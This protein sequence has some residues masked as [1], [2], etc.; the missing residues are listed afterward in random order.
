M[1]TIMRSFILPALLI[2]ASCEPKPLDIDVK[3][4]PAAP[5]VSS[6]MT[7]DHS[8]VIAATYSFNS[9]IG[10]DDTLLDD[11]K[12]PE[13]LMIKDAVVTLAKDGGSADTLVPVSEG[14]FRNN[15]STP[16]NGASY[17]LNIYDRQSK[18]LATARSTYFRQPNVLKLEP[19]KII[20]QGDTA[21]RLHIKL[22]DV[23]PG[24]YYMVSYSTRG[25]RG[26]NPGNQGFFSSLAAYNP[27]QL[28]LLG[29]GEI[30][31]DG[32]DQTVTIAAKANDT[33]LVHCCRIDKAYYNYLNTYKKAGSFINQFTGEPVNLPTNV[34]GGIG[35]F[36][37]SV[38]VRAIFQLRDY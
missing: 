27:K 35:Y 24:D 30:V 25:N 8:V 11:H 10:L 29:E 16:E 37:M 19:V 5:A 17:T 22:G 1:N 14:I 6:A 33:L 34:T 9:L 21:V 15:L 38:P 4:Q 7:G 31:N 23:S 12:I 26:K 32:I 2:F 13:E 20:S 28:V 36:A 3:Q 18:L